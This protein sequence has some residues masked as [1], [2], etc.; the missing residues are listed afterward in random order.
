MSPLWAQNGQ[1]DQGVCLVEIGDRISVEITGSITNGVSDYE[2]QRAADIIMAA[3]ALLK[4]LVRL[5]PHLDAIIC[6]ASDMGEHEP[7][8]IAADV[9][10]W[11][12]D[13]RDC[14]ALEELGL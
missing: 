10:G 6:F 9:R 1:T 5:E 12:S 7:N 4:L 13:L 3:P 2:V 11:V 14:G 8:A